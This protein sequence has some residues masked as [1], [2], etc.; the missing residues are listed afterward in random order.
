LAI[1]GH[2]LVRRPRPLLTAS[3]RFQ[4]AL[5]AIARDEKLICYRGVVPLAGA[6]KGIAEYGSI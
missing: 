3:G 4:L 1:S 6:T 2:E 5:T